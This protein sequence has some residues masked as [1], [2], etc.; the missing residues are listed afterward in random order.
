V[1]EIMNEELNHIPELS[2]DQWNEEYKQL[3][4]ELN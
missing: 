2:V 3:L 1:N 4:D